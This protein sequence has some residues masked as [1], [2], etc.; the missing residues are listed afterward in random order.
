MENKNTF[1]DKI[2]PA[3]YSEETT[4]K[5]LANYS[6]ASNGRRISHDACSWPLLLPPLISALGLSRLLSF[7]TKPKLHCHFGFHLRLLSI[8]YSFKV[9]NSQPLN[10]DSEGNI[11]L[12]DSIHHPLRLFH[13]IQG[14]VQAMCPLLCRTS[15]CVFIT[16]QAPRY[17]I[18]W[19]SKAYAAH[20]HQFACF[21][22][23]LSSTA[24]SYLALFLVINCFMAVLYNES[25]C[26]RDGRV[27]TPGQN[28]GKNT[29]TADLALAKVRQGVGRH[30]TVNA[31]PSRNAS[32]R[33][34]HILKCSL[35]TF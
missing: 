19:G 17:V 21:P 6:I 4:A 12:V 32:T 30:H 15:R 29:G 11:A 5:P 33:A 35:K 7:Y 24:L 2:I 8:D 31:F 14:S 13:K 26:D 16:Q 18:H 9:I 3:Y 34:V 1:T 28:A 20:W 25:H 23:S 27:V 22:G 10:G